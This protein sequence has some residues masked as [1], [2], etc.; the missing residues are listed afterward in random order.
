MLSIYKYCIDGSLFFG[1]Y[2]YII[3]IQLRAEREA[4]DRLDR[5]MKAARDQGLNEED[6]IR[7]LEKAMVCCC[8]IIGFNA[9]KHNRTARADESTNTRIINTN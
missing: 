8:V 6:T 9:G 7:V 4:K 3:C 5:I 1:I 2:I